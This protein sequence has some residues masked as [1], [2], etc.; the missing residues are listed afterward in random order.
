M[1]ESNETKQYETKTK[2]QTKTKIY[3]QQKHTVNIIYKSA[4][5]RTLEL[6]K[7]KLS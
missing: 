4:P 6:K 1:L 5:T 2:G 7:V 3:T